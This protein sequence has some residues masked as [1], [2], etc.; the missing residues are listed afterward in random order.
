MVRFLPV[1]ATI[2]VYVCTRT[3]ASHM[4][5]IIYS[6]PQPHGITIR[7]YINTII[8]TYLRCHPVR[9]P[10]CCPPPPSG[11]THNCRDT[12]IPIHMA[13][14]LLQRYLHTNTHG[15]LTT[16]E[17]PTYQY[18]WPAHYCRDTYIPIHMA[19]S[20]LQRYLHTNT[21]GLL[22]TAEI[23]TYQYTWTAHME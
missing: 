8:H 17:I 11:T 23:P 6:L 10:N 16:A 12:Y 14:S 5:S 4:L 1:T 22:T 2:Y 20:L 7:T 19:C 18:T 15:L 9:R 21:H 13:C 3:H